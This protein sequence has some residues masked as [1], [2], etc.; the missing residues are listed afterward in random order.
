MSRF[1]LFCFLS[2]VFFFV[3]AL[4][5]STWSW[6]A[7]IC[8]IFMLC[9]SIPFHTQ[10]IS[11][12]LPLNFVFVVRRSLCGHFKYYFDFEFCLKTCTAVPV[13]VIKLLFAWIKNN[14]KKAEEND[15]ISSSTILITK[16]IAMKAIQLYSYSHKIYYFRFQFQ[17]L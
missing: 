7:I 8:Q 10:T 16:I 2:R 4:S 11:L 3:C 6:P 14:D 1:C 15:K 12:T 9:S 17:M 13:C 5:I